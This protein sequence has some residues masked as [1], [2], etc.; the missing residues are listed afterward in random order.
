M[1]ID[2]MPPIKRARDFYLYDTDGNRILD[3]YL[4]KGRAISGHRPGGLSL[5]IKN[6]IS[7]GLYASYPSIYTER[8]VKL[9]KKEFPQFKKI[10]LYQSEMSFS[11]SLEENREFSDSLVKP[12]N[13]EYQYWRPYIK[14][15]GECRNLLVRFPF[16]GSDTV[17]VLS[18]EDNDLPE[19]DIIPPYILAGLIR[20]YYNLKKRM[21][22]VDE[23]SWS[24]LDDTGHWNR[25]GPYLFPRC[26][27]EEYEKL[28]R[29]YL[30]S[31]VLISPYYDR[32]TI[33]AVDLLAGSLKKLYRNME[34]GK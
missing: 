3:L 25:T 1:L 27:E 22:T 20:A 31:D 32:P 5:A 7:R 13:Q 15:S 11:K 6:A 8:L 29:L 24:L 30:K 21:E 2:L 17:A 14:I 19:S 4:D 26:S 10:G 34:G 9:L 18:I 23:S 28:F 12:G 33:C 16:P